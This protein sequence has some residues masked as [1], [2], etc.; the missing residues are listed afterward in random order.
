MLLEAEARGSLKSRTLRLKTKNKLG[1]K[2]SL[3]LI[4]LFYF[5]FIIHMCIQGLGHLIFLLICVFSLIH[6]P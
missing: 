2:I 6:I 5:F 1:D 4:F 3:A